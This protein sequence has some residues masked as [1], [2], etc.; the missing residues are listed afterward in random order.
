MVMEPISNTQESDDVS[1][2]LYIS[3]VAETIRGGE[4]PF[5]DQS[6]S[7]LLTDNFLVFCSFT[8]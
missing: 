3:M 1:D 7:G 4:T 5:Y 8:T 2:V 6:K